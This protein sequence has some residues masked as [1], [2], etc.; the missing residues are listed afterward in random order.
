EVQG[1]DADCSRGRIEIP[2]LRG[3]GDEVQAMLGDRAA[4]RGFE[5]VTEGGGLGGELA[6]AGFQMEL[7]GEVG[8]I[9]PPSQ[10]EEIVPVRM[11]R[12]RRIA[13]VADRFGD[14]P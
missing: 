14:E 1:R 7:P 10:G 13:L 11:N 5:I 12:L 3:A 2:Q 6:L 9:L 4:D 8:G